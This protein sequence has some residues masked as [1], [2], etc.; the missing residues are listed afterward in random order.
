[1]CYSQG[2]TMVGPYRLYKKINAKY[3]DYVVN[4]LQKIKKEGSL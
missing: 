4:F 1:V 3:Y 2:P